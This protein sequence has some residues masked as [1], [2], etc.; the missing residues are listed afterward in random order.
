MYKTAPLDFVHC[1]NYKI[2]MFWKLDSAVFN[3]K[4]A[5][6]DRESICWGS[7][8]ELAIELEVILV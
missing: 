1:L 3:K 4:R 6:E 5:E 8:V 7:L 2:T